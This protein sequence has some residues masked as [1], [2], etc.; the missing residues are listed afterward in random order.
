MAERRLLLAIVQHFP[1]LLTADSV[2][3]QEILGHSVPSAGQ[4]IVLVHFEDFAQVRPAGTA[5][6]HRRN[7]GWSAA[8]GGATVRKTG[9]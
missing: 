1:E 3:E 8:R 2:H 7:R 6:K 4:D 5:L 9:V